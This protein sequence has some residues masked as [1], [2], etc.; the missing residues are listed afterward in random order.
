MGFNRCGKE[1]SVYLKKDENDFLIIAIYID[2]FFVT[3][4]LRK[5]IDQFKK[6]MSRE[7]EMSDLGK[8]TYYLGIEVIQGADGIQIK[9]KGYPQGII[10][11]TEMDSCNLTHVPMESNLK[12]SKAEKEKEIDATACRRAIGCLR[13]LLHTRPDTALL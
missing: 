12:I 5:V 8:L 1:P 10:T 4:T 3:G 11:D 6:D 2:D 9:Q 13:Y 7:F